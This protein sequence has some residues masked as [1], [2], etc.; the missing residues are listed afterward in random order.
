[1]PFPALAN[2]AKILGQNH[3]AESTGM[4]SLFFI[5]F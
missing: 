1:M 2:C 5:Q 4:L 3:F